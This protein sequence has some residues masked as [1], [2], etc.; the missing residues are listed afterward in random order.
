MKKN[1]LKLRKRVLQ[2]LDSDSMLGDI[3]GGRPRLSV[4]RCGRSD[5]YSDCA[6]ECGGKC[7]GAKITK[8]CNKPCD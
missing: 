2:V 5:R 1:N 7:G 6:T 4:V 8:S 3:V